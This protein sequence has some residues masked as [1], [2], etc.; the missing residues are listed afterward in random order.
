MI[1]L[2]NIGPRT[3]SNYN[4]LEEIMSVNEDISFDGIYLNVYE[5]REHLLK[6]KKRTGKQIYLFAQLYN[7]GMDNSMDEGAP[8]LEKMCSMEQINAL[9]EYLDCELGYHSWHHINLTTLSAERIEEEIY[10]PFKTKW[11]A[12]PHGDVD[13]KVI[14]VVK[15]TGY[16]EDAW[17]VT[18]GNGDR[19]QRKRRYLNW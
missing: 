17:S 7:M 14:D 9:V 8:K 3:H 12:Y 11:F 19:F 1:L 18:Q 4:T 13:Q 10:P 6:W 2:H 5:H 15:K 16:Y